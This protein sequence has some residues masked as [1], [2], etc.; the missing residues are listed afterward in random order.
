MQIGRIVDEIDRLGY[1]E[2]TLVLYIWGDNGASAEGQDG[3]ISELLA[4]N[5]IP[6]TT[7]QHITALQRAWWSRCAWLSLKPIFYV[8]RWLGLGGQYALSRR[9][10]SSLPISV[11]RVIRWLSGG[12]QRSSTTQRPAPQFLHVNDVVP[13]HL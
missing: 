4:Q 3:T 2:N 13:T 11:A 6:S 1:G 5:G 9:L 12:L 8:S 10:S 7:K